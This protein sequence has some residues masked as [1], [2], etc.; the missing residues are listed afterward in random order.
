[1]DLLARVYVTV[2][3]EA[4][5]TLCPS[6]ALLCPSV[7]RKEKKRNRE[8]GT[9]VFMYQIPTIL[10]SLNMHLLSLLLCG[11]FKKTGSRV[12]P[13]HGLATLLRE[14]SDARD[15]NLITGGLL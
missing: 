7:V 8:K 15:D 2:L 5:I 10:Q 3:A 13:P 9:S 6:S 12:K 14:N 11:L 1:L 4:P